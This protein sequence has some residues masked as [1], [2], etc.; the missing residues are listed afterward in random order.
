MKLDVSQIIFDYLKTLRGVSWSISSVI[1]VGLV[2]FTPVAASYFSYFFR[3]EIQ[4][5]LFL[6]LF[7]LF[8]IFVAIFISVQGV[9]VSLYETPRPGSSDPVVDDRHKSEN[10]IKKRLIKEVSFSLSYMNLFSLISMSILIFPIAFNSDL[11]LFKWVSI[12]LATHLV[13][14]L[15]VILKRMHALFSHQFQ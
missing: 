15:F 4:N 2:F 9:L 13:L 6:S 1:D 7:T 12:F 14:N 3:S 10:L 8:G 5:E 11:F